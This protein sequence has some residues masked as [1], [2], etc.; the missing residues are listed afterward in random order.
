[1]Q[2]SGNFIIPSGRGYARRGEL[3]NGS[4]R[5]AKCLLSVGLGI[6][7]SLTAMASQAAEQE[8]PAVKKTA[9]APQACEPI[10]LTR[11]AAQ[12]ME[13]SNLLRTVYAQITLTPEI[14]KIQKSLPEVSRQIDLDFTDTSITLRG[15]PPLETLEAQQALW[16]RRQ[17]Q[18]STWMTLLTQ[19]TVEI[20]EMMNRIASLHAIWTQ[21]RESA[22][23]SQ[24]PEATLQQIETVLNAIEAAQVPLR[25]RHDGLLNLQTSV[26]E[27][28]SRCDDMLSR[29]GQAQKG[30][31]SGILVRERPPIWNVE[32]WVNAKTSLSD[33]M[34][35]VAA[36]FWD[37][38]VQYVRDS[39][40]E[41]V[42]EVGLFLLLTGTFV[43]A[44]HFLH[45]RATEDGKLSFVAKVFD[46]PYSASL[47]AAW[48][49]AT[50]YGSPTPPLVKDLLTALAIIPIVRLVQPAMSSS[51]MPGIIAL[52]GLY[53]LDMFRGV[54]SGTAVF[55]QVVLVVEGVTS[56]A[57]LGWLL[58]SRNLRE[59][60]P[61]ETGASRAQTIEAFAK[62]VM[63]YLA[64]GLVC[65]ALGYMRLGRIVT[66]GT[67][68]ASAVALALYASAR[69]AGGAVAV[70]L[71]MWPLR[72][73]QM[74]QHH[75]DVLEKQAYRLLVWLAVL[76]WAVRSL[77]HIGLLEPIVSVG[78]A[79]LATK[80]ERGSISVSIGDILAFGLTIW[81]SFLVSRFIRFALQEEV[82]P[83]SRIPSGTAY[84]S[85]RLLHYTI[86]ALGFV[87]GLGVLGI[88]LSKVSVIAGAF[89][90]GIGF[91]LQ[92]VVNNF[93]C[94]LILLFERPIH[95][96]DTIEVGDLLGEVRRIGFRASTV[97]VRNGAD[98]II[99]NAQFITANVTN[100]TLSDQLRRLELPVGVNYGA[101]PQAVIELLVRTAQAHS[102][103]LKNPPP[104]GIFMGY[105]DSSINFELRA[106]TDEFRNWRRVRSD[107]ATAVYDAVRAAGMS[108]P[109]PQREVRVLSD[110]KPEEIA[111]PLGGGTEPA[112]RGK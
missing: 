52:A 63:V 64:V 19:R 3:K 48:F 39:S 44:G 110:S 92:S 54:I 8:T 30:A 59:P 25:A 108:F 43:V 29:I 94:G 104:V 7:L 13:V 69:V 47:L 89:G 41:M 4:P 16:Q 51:K 20:Q 49:F 91:G 111:S 32:Q 85:S 99:P 88:D 40:R 56:I 11:V 82:Y 22:Q 83:R 96:G 15:Q 55:E 58:A 45:R 34:S 18:V 50:R 73:M 61:Q 42:L 2:K 21:T 90:V 102:A 65:A 84:A 74:V 57:L 86:L 23:K 66:S 10:P 17:L 5:L 68:T 9:P 97:R 71:R 26:S 72:L 38:L 27:E 6:L 100:W 106:W 79:I 1:M 35:V 93:V 109:F 14:E 24:A 62:F 78:S 60:Y 101:A 12:A 36:G 76:G 46:R 112:L 87:V 80:L 77:D 103:I 28:L 107:L 31:V 70:V 75:S 98:I 95:V 67:I 81:A 37:D 53:A 105:G 33:R